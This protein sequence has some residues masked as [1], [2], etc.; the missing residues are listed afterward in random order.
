MGKGKVFALPAVVKL[1]V[2]ESILGV[3][4]I[5]HEPRGDKARFQG[6]Q[7]TPLVMG[8][9]CEASPE[10]PFFKMRSLLVSLLHDLLQPLLYFLNWMNAGRHTTPPVETTRKR[11]Q[12]WGF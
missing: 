3:K 9:G 12:I 8:K 10:T 4:I 5:L 2:L 7:G 1:L 6:C 11:S